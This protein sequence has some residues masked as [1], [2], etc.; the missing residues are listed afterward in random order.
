[1]E[2][3]TINGQPIGYETSGKG[4]PVLFLHGF[5]EDRRIW[6]EF[7]EPMEE[8]EYHFIIADL[9]GFGDSPLVEPASIDKMADILL[10]F[11]SALGHEEFLLVGHSMGGY[12][13]LAMVE[14]AAARIEALVLFHSHPFSDSEE[15]KDSRNK[16]IE[17]IQR[18]GHELYVKQLLNKLFYPLYISSHRYIMDRLIYHASNYSP[19]GIINALEAMRD[20]PDRSEILRNIGCPVQ[21]IIGAEEKIIPED[22]S[23]EQTHLPAIGSIDLIARSNHMA[24]FEA[25]KEC[26][27]ILKRF[28]AF[29]EDQKA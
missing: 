29:A 20:R 28:F 12:I 5:C 3:L 14:K 7:L 9:P 25:A 16:G 24:M 15:K 19:E 26:R 13:S 17:F 18:N 8:E 10:Q 21:F 4:K 1:M 23:M 22:L 11:M 6:T 2:Q 27:R